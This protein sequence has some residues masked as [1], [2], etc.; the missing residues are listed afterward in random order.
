MTQQLPEYISEV[1]EG[2]KITLL[3]PLDI[4]GAKVSEIVMRE[5]T[6]QDLLAAEMQAKS[7]GAAKQE[8]VMFANLCDVTPEQIQATTLRNYGRLQ[9]AFKLFTD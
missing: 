6:V 4:D 8:I 3:K 2:Y 7:L 9:A 5:P 1:A